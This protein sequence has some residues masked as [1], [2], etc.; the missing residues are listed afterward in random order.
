MKTKISIVGGGACALMLGCELDP[1]KFEVTLY[2]KNAALGRKFLVAGEGG[3]NLTHSENTANFIKRY[4]PY[5]FFEEAFSHFSNEELRTWFKNLG[6][7]TYVG[8]SGRVFPL[9]GTKPIEVLNKLLERLKKNKVFV[10]TKHTLLDFTKDKELVFET[11]G[12]K[13]TIK[14]DLVIFCMGG[15]SWPVTGSTGNWDELLKSHAIKINPFQASNSSFKIEWPQQL[16][17]KLEGK[18]LKNISITCQTKTQMGEVVLT[19]FGIEGSGIYPFSPD[20]R[21]LLEQKGKAEICIDLKPSF[22]LEKIIEKLKQKPEKI[23]LTEYLKTNLH[24]SDIQV[25]LIKNFLS[26][27][28]YLDVSSLAT[29]IKQFT[30]SVTA[31]GPIEDAISTVGGVDLSEISADFELK[32]I[33]RHFVVGEML[34]YDAPTG[35][36]LLQSCFSMACFLAKRINLSHF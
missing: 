7:E 21:L 19:R 12:I 13:K 34:D 27:E 15:A 31:M 36:Y 2:E 6:I 26:K 11:N 30:L 22:S 23:N 25:V 3:L 9:T 18:V 10:L 33:P 1:E 32:K 29:R 8:S 16:I 24:L 5:G 14:S 35:G 20:I 28:D 17:A 4:T